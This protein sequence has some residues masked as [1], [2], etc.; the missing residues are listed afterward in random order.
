MRRFSHNGHDL[1]SH[2]VA[3]TILSTMATLKLLAM[4]CWLHETL[5]GLRLPQ[6]CWLRTT[7]RP[8]IDVQDFSGSRSFNKLAETISLQRWLH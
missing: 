8:R 1:E 7:I 6:P 2:S 3:R 5:R 4:F